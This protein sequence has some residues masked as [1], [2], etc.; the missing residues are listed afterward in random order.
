MLSGFFYKH[1]F[2][3]KS[4]KNLAKQLKK[5][6]GFWPAKLY[7]YK[8]AL[9]H[10]SVSKKIHESGSKDSNERLEFLG[11]SVFNAV[12][13]DYIFKKYPYKDEGFLTQMRSKIVSRESLNNLAQ[14]IGLS[15]LV[16]YDK[17]SMQ[18]VN[19]RNSIFGNALEAFIG[20]IYL[21]AGYKTCYK[22]II[23]VLLLHN[24]DIDKLEEIETNFKGRLIEYC[25]KNNLLI[26]FECEEAIEN[27]IKLFKVSIKLNNEIFGQ[28][29]NSNKKKAEQL[30][31]QRTFEMIKKS[32]QILP[33]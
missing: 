32:G 18:N 15:H 1:F 4:D 20:A 25:Q 13:S 26:D 33:E 24:L 10:H 28:A 16:Q 7:G 2:R 12:I 11:D 30:A 19:L 31:S 29:E 8:Q 21:D 27:K 5:I 9:R 6:T 14:K 22:F 17:K 3:N 23:N